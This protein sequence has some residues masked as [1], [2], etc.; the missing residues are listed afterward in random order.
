M[1]RRTSLVLSALLVAACSAPGTAAPTG[2]STATPTPP[3]TTPAAG[4]GTPTAEPGTP[5]AAEP[6]AGATREPSS[7][8]VLDQAWATA[9]LV[10]VE[11]GE[12]FRI[13]DLAGTTVILEPMAIWCT[14]CLAQQGHVEEA[15]GQLDRERVAYVLLDVDPNETAK[16][17][18]DFRRRH[19]FTGIY[20]VANRDVARALAAEFGDQV[21]N[22]PST[23]MI[24]IG[25]DGRVTLTAFGQKRVDEVVALAREHGA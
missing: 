20:A 11:T 19:G 8:P 10:D 9:E 6:S 3:M 4:S 25:A 21:L 14:K 22:P 16:A 24:L 15:L 17:L 18:K 2:E 7:T 23:P 5:P 12:P 1:R 13:A